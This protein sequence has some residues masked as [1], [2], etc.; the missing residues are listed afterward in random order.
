MGRRWGLS[1]HELPPTV[2]RSVS[3]PDLMTQ[4]TGLPP[5]PSPGMPGDRVIA[6][7]VRP[8]SAAAA[9][10]RPSWLLA[11]HAALSLHYGFALASGC[12]K[13]DL[14]IVQGPHISSELI[15][16][17]KRM[18]NTEVGR[19][20]GLA[21]GGERHAWAQ[22]LPE[23]PLL[24]LHEWPYPGSLHNDSSRSSMSGV[25]LCQDTFHGV[26]AVF[27]GKIHCEG[28]LCRDHL[29]TASPATHSHILPWLPTP[30]AT[31]ARSGHPGP[32]PAPPVQH[33]PGT[34]RVH[35]REKLGVRLQGPSKEVLSGAG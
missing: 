4:Q 16:Q 11:G 20:S 9:A 32:L 18:A 22:T 7:E 26:C 13:A 2:P 15:K 1:G 34:G 33:S 31:V 14:Y 6:S 12:L 25:L 28:A 29:S 10:P 23:M 27:H 24:S 8:G 35:C 5:G 21:G 3:L 19:V 17:S 30:V